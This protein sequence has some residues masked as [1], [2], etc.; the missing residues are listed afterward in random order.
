MPVQPDHPILAG[1][2]FIPIGTA[3]WV[4]VAPGATEILRL[5]GG[6][7]NYPLTLIAEKRSGA[8]DV[9][10]VTFNLNQ[11]SGMRNLDLFVQ[12]VITYLLARSRLG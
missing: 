5:A 8:G 6:P 4:E 10:G 12:N 3:N 11:L 7:K 2:E 9:L 1:V